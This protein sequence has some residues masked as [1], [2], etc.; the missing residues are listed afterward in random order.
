MV[1]RRIGFFPITFDLAETTRMV[2]IALALREL[3]EYEP[4]LFSHGGHYES[5]ITRHDLIY[6]PVKPLF[7]QKE[8]DHFWRLDTMETIWGDIFSRSFLKDQ[9]VHEMEVFRKTEIEMVVTGF[10][11][12]CDLSARAVGVPLV[13]VIPATAVRLYMESG[14]ASFPDALERRMLSIVPQTWKDHFYT[15]MMRRPDFWVKPF[16]QV[17]KDIGI[18]PVADTMWDLWEGDHTLL[19][20]LLEFI[21]LP[22]DVEV[23]KENFTGPLLGNLEMDLEPE[24]EAHLSKSDRSIFFAMGS[25]GQKELFLRVLE[26]LGQTDYPVVAAYTTILDE[27]D[28][29]QV[30]PNIMLRK[31]VPA[32]PVS[33]LAAL[34]IIHGGQGTVYTAAYSGRPAIGIPMQFEQ[35]YNLDCLLTHHGCGI[36][37]SR[38]SSAKRTSWT[39]SR[40]FLKITMPITRRQ[41]LWPHA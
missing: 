29:P 14:R 1:A 37:L 26:A 34:S 12:P 30:A 39:L 20:D 2:N 15:W 11:L 41:R 28:L 9:V 24:I 7:T 35:Q 32:E 27:A 22:D 38:D 23:I 36:R 21:D 31:L 25:S 18:E 6:I 16:T 3:G 33:K 5:V 13:W 19:S 10:N 17:A 4:I 8:I 40:R